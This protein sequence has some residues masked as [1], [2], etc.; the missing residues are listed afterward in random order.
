MSVWIHSPAFTL[1]QTSTGN[2]RLRSG[3]VHASGRMRRQGKPWRSHTRGINLTTVQQLTGVIDCKYSRICSV[4]NKWT[5][6]LKSAAK[7]LTVNITIW[8]WFQI[9]LLRWDNNPKRNWL[10]M[11][12]SLIVGEPPIYILLYIYYTILYYI[13]LYYYIILCYVILYYIIILCYV[14]LYSILLYYIIFYYIYYI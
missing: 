6:T 13:I 8:V 3:V 2:L 9:A 5:W 1:W 12:S 11:E 10:P 14:I 7:L 4:E